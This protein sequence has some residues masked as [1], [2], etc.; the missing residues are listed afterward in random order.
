MLQLV[1]DCNRCVMILGRVPC[2]IHGVGVCV[3]A[4]DPAARRGLREHYQRRINLSKRVCHLLSMCLVMTL[5]LSAGLFG[6]VQAQASVTGDLNSLNAQMGE[7]QQQI[8]ELESQIESLDYQRQSV[9]EKKAILDQKNALTQQELDVIAEQIAI[10]DNYL[11]NRQADLEA[12][13]A[14]EAEQEAAWLARLRAMEEESDLSYIQVLFEATSFSDLLTRLD[15]V[16][17]ITQYDEELF[18]S[19]IAARENVET[20][21]AEAEEMYALNEQNK[22]AYE[23]KQAQLEADT[24]AACDMIAALE[25]DIDAY[26]E[27]LEEQNVI[28]EELAGQIA[29]ALSA[30]YASLITSDQVSQVMDAVR[31]DNANFSGDGTTLLWPSWSNLV[32]SYFGNRDAPLGTNGSY[33]STNHK[34]IDIAGSGIAGSSVWAAGNG[35]VIK[36]GSD[37]TGF[38]NYVIVALDNGYTVQYSHLA[39][40]LVSEGQTVSQGQSVGTVGSTGTATGPHIDFRIYDSNGNALDPMSFD[41]TYGS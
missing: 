36:T 26:Q 9:L 17:E 6:S 24:Q 25:E 16:S 34:G 19:Y 4:N 33:G 28:E 10:I 1:T 22:A 18:N 2:I 15:F 31:N 8:S 14:Q 21:E 41:Y 35:T 38:G 11:A 12:A 39:E 20:L 3:K 40:N 27:M 37:E 7:I 32:T 29:E 30:Y 23:E 5:V 13:R